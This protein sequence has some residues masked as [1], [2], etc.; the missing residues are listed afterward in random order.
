MVNQQEECNKQKEN[1]RI[2]V[3]GHLGVEIGNLF[4]DLQVN[5]LENGDAELSGYIA[6]QSALFGVLSHIHHLGFS[7]LLVEKIFVSSQ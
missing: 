7:L 1:Y 4:S 3:R 6:D 2:R 5:N